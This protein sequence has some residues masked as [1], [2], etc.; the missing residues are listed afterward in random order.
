MIL[1]AARV[2]AAGFGAGL[3]GPAVFDI[4]RFCGFDAGAAL[5]VSVV[6]AGVWVG[7]I[8][9]TPEKRRFA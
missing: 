3:V 2:V 9:T 5:F 8:A 4:A 1:R 6:L 7:L